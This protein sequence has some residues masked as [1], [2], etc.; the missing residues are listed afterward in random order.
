MYV[1]L[2]SSI[3][4]NKTGA[5]LDAAIAKARAF[6]TLA[7]SNM[8]CQLDLLLV[9]EKFSSRCTLGRTALGPAANKKAH[10]I[11]SLSPSFCLI[12]CCLPVCSRA[13]VLYPVNTLR[14]YARLQART[15]LIGLFDADM[16]PSLTLFLHLSDPEE[17]KRLER[18]L[19]RLGNDGC[20]S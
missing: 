13:T 5:A 20:G 4:P 16:L 3:G 8:S 7:E 17:F 10:P 1:A 6:H 18:I 11:H 12:H 2:D 15:P 9:Y 19:A 14:N